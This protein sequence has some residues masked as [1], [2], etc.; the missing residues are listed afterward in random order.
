MFRF[1]LLIRKNLCAILLYP[2]KEKDCDQEE[3][4][5]QYLS[6]D[7]GL[8]EKGLG[9]MTEDLENAGLSKIG[10]RFMRGGLMQYQHCLGRQM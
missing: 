5:R 4:M 10:L 9:H 6:G 8:S 7:T 3:I 1:I 2:Q